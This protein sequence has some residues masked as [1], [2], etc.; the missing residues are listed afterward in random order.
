MFGK[1]IAST[2]PGQ[3]GAVQARSALWGTRRPGG[4]GRQ[5]P[6]GSDN[7]HENGLL[8]GWPLRTRRALIYFEAR[9][10]QEFSNR[11]A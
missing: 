1:G 4:N 3:R 5:G 10:N 9:K 8:S 7:P 11:I 6:A 2:R